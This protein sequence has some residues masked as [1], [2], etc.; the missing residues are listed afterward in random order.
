MTKAELRTLIL[1]SVTLLVSTPAPVDAGPTFPVAL[2]GAFCWG[3]APCS[4]GMW[5]LYE[6]GRFDSPGG[7]EG[8]WSWDRHDRML[9]MTYDSGTVYEGWPVAG[10]CITGEMKSYRGQLGEWYACAD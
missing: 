9:Q 6:T 1:L 7:F 4:D 2:V 8:D 5:T 10:R 3:V